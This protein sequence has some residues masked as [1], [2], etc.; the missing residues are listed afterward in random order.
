VQR[1]ISKHFVCARTDT[2][3]D[4]T[5]GGSFAHKPGDAEPTCVRGNGKQNVQMLFLTP[6]GEIFHVL[7]GY[8]GAA[9]LAADLKRTRA[10]FGKVMAE[11]DLD[12]REQIV[13]QAHETRRGELADSD[14]DGPLGSFVK[15]RVLQEQAF[16][17]QH[18]LLRV[19]DFRPVMLVGNG[20]T[21]FGSSRGAKPTERIGR[22][23]GGGL[24]GFGG[25]PKDP[26]EPKTGSE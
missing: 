22:R 21:F 25:D 12:R 23:P 1:E 5:A 8:I 16:V 7:T 18:P 14:F 4:P 15:R 17:A 3:G 26:K 24:P 19:E 11:P 13:A 10:L 2:T 9:E 20:R 6:Q